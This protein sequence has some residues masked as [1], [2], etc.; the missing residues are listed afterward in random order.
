[1]FVE[2][3]F[4]E[5]TEEGREKDCF[6]VILFRSIVLSRLESERMPGEDGM[7]AKR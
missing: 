3:V 5:V 2:V 4:V 7:L 6:E 1:L